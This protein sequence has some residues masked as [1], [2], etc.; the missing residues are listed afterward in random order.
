MQSVSNHVVMGVDISASPFLATLSVNSASYYR[1]SRS[2]QTYTSELCSYNKATRSTSCVQ[3]RT[4]KIPGEVVTYDLFYT[5]LSG[6]NVYLMAFTSDLSSNVVQFEPLNVYA[7]IDALPSLTM[8]YTVAD[9]ECN[10]LYIFVTMRD[11]PRIVIF[12]ADM[13]TYPE[14][15]TVNSKSFT[16]EELNQIVRFRPRSVTLSPLNTN[17]LFIR[18]LQSVLIMRFSRNG[19]RLISNIPVA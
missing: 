15:I 9:L 4:F 16:D 11:D 14:V 18:N 19:L 3:K 1:I 8:D 13:N 2:F 7:K 6:Q 5:Q 12:Q 17:I 10:R